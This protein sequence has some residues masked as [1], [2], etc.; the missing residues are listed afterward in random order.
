LKEGKVE[1]YSEHRS[2]KNWAIFGLRIGLGWIFLWSGGRFLWD[3]LSG[4]GSTTSGFLQ[5]ATFGPFAD[6]FQGLAGNPLV[7]ALFVWGLFLAGLGLVLGAMT[8]VAAAG[9]AA[10]MLLIYLSAWPPEHNPVVD[11]HIIYV[12]S[13]VL[14][15]FLGAGRFLGVDGWIE[16][17]RFV[18][19]RPKLRAVLG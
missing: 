17:R 14:L 18:K 8:R 4:A 15:M 7:D 3:S 16:G 6:F 19:R 9:G 11:D 12:L 13:S 10:L 5:F 2:P 1:K